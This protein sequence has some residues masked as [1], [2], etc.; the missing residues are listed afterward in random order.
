MI[1]ILTKIKAFYKDLNNSHIGE[2]TAN[3]AYFI[4]LAFIPFLILIITLTKYFGLDNQII[5]VAQT[6]N[7]PNNMLNNIL[8]QIV[9]EI[10]SKSIGTITISV[11][12]V[13]LSAGKGF[14]ALCKG[15]NA[16]YGLN[17]KN[18]YIYFRI[19]GVFYTLIFILIIILSLIL[20]VFG[21]KINSLIQKNFNIFSR[22]LNILL[23]NKFM[24]SINILTVIFILMYKFIPN[25]KVKF[26]NQLPG[27]L[28]SSI[29]CN[30]I[31]IFYSM[32]VNIYT[33]FSI[34]YGSLTTI[35]LAMMWV[36]ACMYVI[37][38]GGFINKKVEEVKR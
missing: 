36:Y 9:K 31:S 16:V 38:L 10:Y 4:L 20:L 30:I 29:A 17:K 24:I 14:Y 37:L 19:R 3:C 12:F 23:L 15:L 32:Y 2:Y 8:T 22:V 25:H 26:K 13:L 33:G 5:T 21:N 18:K 6:N 28:F 27:A 7:L 35:V 1:K 34:M 11:V